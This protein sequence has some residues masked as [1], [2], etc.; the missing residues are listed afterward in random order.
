MPVNFSLA[1]KIGAK[2]PTPP[3][4]IPIDP[5]SFITQW[6]TFSANEVLTLP[7]PNIGVYNFIVDWGD[8]SSDTITAF[9]QA[10]ISHTYVTPDFYDMTITGDLPAWSF[11]GTGSKLRIFDIKQWGSTG[12]INL[13]GGFKGCSNLGTVT[14]TDV[15]DL[16]GVTD[17]SEMFFT[18]GSLIMDVSGWDVSTIVNMNA[19]FRSALDFNSPIN[20]W[21]VS[22]VTNMEAMFL[23]TNAFNQSLSS[24]NTANVTN[25]ALM[26]STASAYDQ[27]LSSFNIGLVTN[28]SFFFNFSALSTA[29]YDALLIAMEGQTVQTAVTFSGGTSTYSAGAAAT[30]RANLIA[31]SAWV[32][33]DGG[34]A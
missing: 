33:T 14:A 6:R 22:N 11:N 16:S 29:N 25:M 28:M 27:D 23:G 15:P 3:P 18:S 8:G 21:N 7:L 34:P 30:A 20:S 17:I 12:F 5:A 4:P 2:N 13:A 1:M 9:N 32:I 26:F 10:E 19:L 31:N 24:W